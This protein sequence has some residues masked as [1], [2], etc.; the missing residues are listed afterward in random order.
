MTILKFSSQDIEDYPIT[1]RDSLIRSKSFAY[2]CIN[3]SIWRIQG[4]ISDDAQDLIEMS[5][6]LIGENNGYSW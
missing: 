3:A 2:L 1:A 5:D 6:H 4:I